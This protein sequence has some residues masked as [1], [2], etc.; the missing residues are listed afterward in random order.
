M[1]ADQFVA[2]PCGVCKAILPGQQELA[3]GF[4]ALISISE[5]GAVLM[6]R[7]GQHDA[8]SRLINCGPGT[9]LMA[10]IFKLTESSQPV[11]VI[12]VHIHC[13]AVYDHLMVYT[14]LC[15]TIVQV[16]EIYDLMVCD[17]RPLPT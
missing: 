5:I 1:G 16:H 9:F 11:C 17:C 8:I 14:K 7:I 10:N 2:E 3:Q 13:V 12:A 15:Q 4:S 6:L